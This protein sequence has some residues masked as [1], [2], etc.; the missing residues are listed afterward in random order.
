MKSNAL[1][2]KF[3]NQDSP[4]DIIEVH[5]ERSAE[6]LAIVL[7]KSAQYWKLHEPEKL[8]EPKVIH[9]PKVV[10]PPF[11]KPVSNE[12]RRTQKRYMSEFRI[13][14]I[15]G[16]NSFR[17]VSQDISLGGIRLKKSVPEAF[18]KGDCI[19]YIS[20][21]DSR[22]N[23]EII[24]NVIPDEKDPCRIKFHNPNPQQ[25]NRLNQWLSE[26]ALKLKTAA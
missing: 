17:S 5:D 7:M 24:C 14:L 3:V 25:V 11:K 10:P 1:V 18:V 20:H 16:S 22:E 2:W 4:T 9:Q 15:S 8:Q 6:L 23:I 21:K 13:I 19:A 12:E 26:N